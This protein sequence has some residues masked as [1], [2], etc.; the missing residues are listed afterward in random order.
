MDM[1]KAFKKA[2]QSVF[3]KPFI[4]ADRF[5]FM[6]QVYWA[7]DAVRRDVQNTFKKEHRLKTKRSKKLLWMDPAKLDDK[8]QETLQEILNLHADLKEAYT[9][10]NSLNNWFKTSDLHT[11]RYGLEAWFNEVERSQLVPFKKV[12]KTFKNWFQEILNAFVY[13]FNNGYIEGINNTTK[14][15]KRLSYGIKSFQRLRKKILFRQAIRSSAFR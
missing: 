3:D 8:G 10:K 15:I 13:P 9:L 11:A 5:H 7:L 6:R 1:S 14:V 4:I 12:V 2:V